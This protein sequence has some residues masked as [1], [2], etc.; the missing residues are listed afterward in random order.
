MVVLGAR[1]LEVQ[2]PGIEAA[3]TAL[4]HRSGE[5]SILSS[6][7]QTISTGITKALQT[8][9]AWAGAPGEARFDLNRDFFDVP[10]SPQMLKEIVAAWQAGGISS[11]TKFRMLKRGEVYEPGASFED[12]EARI[13][14][15]KVTPDPG[16]PPSA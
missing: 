1:L 12:E 9:V 4:I 10:M 13:A 3:E 15:S 7:A 8:F 11:E 14:A 2:K 16:A 6:M 5:Q